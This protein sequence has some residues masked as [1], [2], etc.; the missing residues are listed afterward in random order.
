VNN[1][2]M[3]SQSKLPL[4]C[5]NCGGGGGGGGDDEDDNQS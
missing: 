5:Y 2:L 3:A 1:D 4:T